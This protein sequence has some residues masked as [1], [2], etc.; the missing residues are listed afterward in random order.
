MKLTAMAGLWLRTGL[1]WFV[2]TMSFGMYLGIT[3]QLGASSPHAHLGLLG[4]LTSAAFALIHAVADPENTM[5]S[6]GKVHWAAHNLGLIV[7]VSS[8]WMIMR[9]GNDMYGMFIGIG[10][11]ILILSTLGF[12][13]MVWKRLA[14]NG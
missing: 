11:L 12:A 14:Q 5:V 7:Q 1:I 3:Q 10:G 9:T 2:L 6:R 13:A 4:W 8:L